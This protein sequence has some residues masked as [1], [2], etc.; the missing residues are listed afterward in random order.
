MLHFST[1]EFLFVSDGIIQAMVPE[2]F[3]G[4]KSLV[5]LTLAHFRWHDL[6]FRV[7]VKI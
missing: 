7:P 2:I 5:I 1:F 3:T 4:W 6:S